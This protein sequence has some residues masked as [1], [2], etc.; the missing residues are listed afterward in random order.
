M[1]R[2]AIRRELRVNN[3]RVGDALLRLE[4]DR[5]AERTPEGWVLLRAHQLSL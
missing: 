3:A 4:H 1:S 5:L 2:A